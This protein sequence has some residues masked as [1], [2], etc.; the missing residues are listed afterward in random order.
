MKKNILQ[1]IVA[2]CFVLFALQTN[3][4]FAFKEYTSQ[5]D[6]AKDTFTIVVSTNE[7]YTTNFYVLNNDTQTKSGLKI[8]R[9]KI[10]DISGSGDYFC[11]GLVCYNESDIAP[12]NIWATPDPI[13]LAPGD[14]AALTLDFDP[15]GNSGTAHFRYR[16]I[17]SSGKA[18]DSM[19][20]VYTSTAGIEETQ[21]QINFSVYPNPVK[22]NLFLQ[23]ENAD[24]MTVKIID[25]LGNVVY[26]GVLNNETSKVDVSEF[27]NGIYFVK[28]NNKSKA[29]VTKKIII[30]H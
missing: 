4:Q 22:N 16:L 29:V 2:F 24:G 26:S 17:S 15:H 7:V 30:N 19:D 13:S 28:L 14:S 23:A 9:E 21:T 10:A 20:V 27:R 6:Y 8:E 3:A 25:M 11:W 1:S 18:I 12:N 5:V